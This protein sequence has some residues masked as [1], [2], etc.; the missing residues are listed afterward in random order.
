MEPKTK[1]AVY[2]IEATNACN[3]KCSFCPKF[4]PWNKR[5]I[6]FMD[7]ELV[8][9]VD[10]SSTKYTE[11]QFTGEPTLHKQLPE[12]LRRIKDHGVMVGFSTNGTLK[13]RLEAVLDIADII[14]VNDDDFRDPVFAERKNVYVQKLGENY[15]IEDYSRTKLAP[16]YPVCRTP[17]TRVSIHWNGD[18]VPCCKDHSGVHVF[19]NLWEKSLYEIEISHARR[20]FVRSSVESRHNGLCEFCEAPNPHRI[21]SKLLLRM[22]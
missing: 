9:R 12:I 4:V 8:E 5:P 22:L 17:L 10:W 1:L 2:Q 15:P 20:E 19:G 18:V 3:L 11:V 14:T 16:E 6:G 7:P 13:D 21:H